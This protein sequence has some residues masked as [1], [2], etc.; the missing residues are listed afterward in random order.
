MFGRM[1]DRLANRFA[2]RQGMISP[3]Q[4]LK[5]TGNNRYGLSGVSGKQTTCYKKGGAVKVKTQ[6]RN[7]PPKNKY[8]G[9]AETKGRKGYKCGGKVKGRK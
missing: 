6:T 4:R 2:R 8:K 5:R 3:N 9:G 1:R 7:S